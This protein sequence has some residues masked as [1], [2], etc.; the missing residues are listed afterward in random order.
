MGILLCDNLLAIYSQKQITI[1]SFLFYL[2]YLKIARLICSYL[3]DLSL[4]G[5]ACVKLLY[6]SD[7]ADLL[8]KELSMFCDRQV[9]FCEFSF[10][11]L[12]VMLFEFVW[13]I[14]LF[15]HVF[16]Y[17]VV[18]IWEC[19]NFVLLLFCTHGFS[20]HFFFG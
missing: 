4:Q 11:E 16:I 3:D 6:P 8:K 2:I 14:V 7:L 1:C 5:C 19:N 10:T 12:D 20:S 9:I 18:R 17:V 13:K 15:P